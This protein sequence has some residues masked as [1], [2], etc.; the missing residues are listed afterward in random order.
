MGNT[1]QQ[2]QHQGQVIDD[3]SKIDELDVKIIKELLANSRK[4]FSEIA[5][6]YNVT[7]LTVYNRFNELKKSGVI[8]G[9]S[10]IVDFSNFEAEGLMSLRINVNP[11]QLNNF[12][13]EI[14]SIQGPF[15][16]THEQKFKKECNVIVVSLVKNLRELDKLKETLRHHSAVISIQTNVWTYMKVKPDNLKLEN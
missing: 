11:Q 10:I 9:S 15:F 14:R 5:E 3:L 1:K 2:N 7:T 6:K 13:K 8:R 12:L 16:Y 4:P